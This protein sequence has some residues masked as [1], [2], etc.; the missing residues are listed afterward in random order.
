MPLSRQRAAASARD[1]RIASGCAAATD[2][3]PT[4]GSDFQNRFRIPHI[5]EFYAA[6]EGNVSLYNVEGKTGAIGRVPPFLAH[7]F[8]LALVQFD[9]ERGAPARDADGFCMRCAT[10]EVGEAIGRIGNDA[11]N[12]G[13]R[14]EGYTSAADSEQKI[15][16]DVFAPGDAWYRT[17]DLMRKDESG[18]YYFVDRIGDTFRWKGEN[19]AT[20]EVAEAITHFRA[21]PTRMSTACGPRNGRPRRHGRRRR[22][23]GVDLAALRRHLDRRL[24][25]YAR[26]L[27]L[28]IQREIEVTATFKHKKSDLVREGYDPA[29]ATDAI[30]FNDPERQAFVRLDS[31]LYERIQ[32]QQVR[33]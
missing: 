6:T 21:S 33:V 29:S 11:A 14:F 26:P 27:F 22:E 2:C 18:F 10:G 4:S 19:V 23:E 20:S 32:R 12:A 30:Y 15:L 7:R 31:A 9:P 5:L 13:G 1:A 3:G 28:R 25:A 24:P 8:P 17:G 16:R